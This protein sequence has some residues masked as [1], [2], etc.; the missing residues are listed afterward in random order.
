MVDLLHEY[1]ANDDGGEFGPV[2]ERGDQLR[3][4]LIPGARLIFSLR[5]AS[6]HQAMQLYNERLDYGDYQ[7]AEGVE[8]HFYSAEEAAEQEAYLRVRNCR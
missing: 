4:T 2:R 1:W 7:P 8:N 6:W 3:Q 5:A